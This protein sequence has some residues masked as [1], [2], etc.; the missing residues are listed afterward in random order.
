M[1][2]CGEGYFKLTCA[3]LDGQ[4]YDV[5]VRKHNKIVFIKRWLLNLMGVQEVNWWGTTTFAKGGER[6]ELHLVH[7]AVRMDDHMRLQDY[8]IYND[9]TVSIVL[10]KFD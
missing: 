5:S 2:H 3:A 7:E 4:S 9:T 10:T 8:Y 6:V 1:P